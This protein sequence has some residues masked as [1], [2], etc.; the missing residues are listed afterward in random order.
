[1]KKLI[2]AFVSIFYKDNS[3][4]CYE[5]WRPNIPVNGCKKQCKECENKQH[6]K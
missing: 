3:F 2:K 4:D 1:M 5:I 6:S